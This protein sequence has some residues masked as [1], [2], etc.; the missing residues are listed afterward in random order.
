[1]HDLSLPWLAT[2]SSIINS[3][4]YIILYLII[5]Y[6]G[7]QQRLVLQNCAPLLADLFLHVYETDFFQGL[8]KNKD[9][10]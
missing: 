3:Q 7:F 10:K 1:M 8:L 4:I 2:G 6:R 5:S 9:R